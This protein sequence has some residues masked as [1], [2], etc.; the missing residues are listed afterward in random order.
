M[1]LNKIKNG[2][3]LT[4]IWKA[5]LNDDKIL[6][7]RKNLDDSITGYNCLILKP[8]MVRN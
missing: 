4:K 1:P 2:K 3:K 7:L 6:K 5:T 8:K